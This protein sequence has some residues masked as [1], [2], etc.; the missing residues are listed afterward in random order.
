[1]SILQEQAVRMISGLSDENVS[2]LIEIIQR[3]ML[4]KPSAQTAEFSE[5]KEGIQ[6]FLRLD[7]AR[8]EI[9]KYLPED[10]DPDKELEEARVER[11]GSIG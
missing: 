1:M 5:N 8:T 10:F 6:A 9:M 2:F 4:S 11:Y 7:A 3:F